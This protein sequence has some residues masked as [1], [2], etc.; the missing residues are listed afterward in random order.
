MIATLFKGKSREVTSPTHSRT[1]IYFLVAPRSV[2]TERETDR[3]IINMIKAIMRLP[4]SQSSWLQNIISMGSFVAFLILFQMQVL[5]VMN[6]LMH[7]INTET[8]P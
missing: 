2:I 6:L 8:F 1:A 4:K 7:V 5:L 3:N